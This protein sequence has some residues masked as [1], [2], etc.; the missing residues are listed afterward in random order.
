MFQR[1]LLRAHARVNCFFA[2]LLHH[3]HNAMSFIG[4]SGVAAR[5]CYILLHPCT[6]RHPSRGGGRVT[7]SAKSPMFFREAV[8]D[9]CWSNKTGVVQQGFCLSIMFSNVAE[10]D[11]Q[12]KSLLNDSCFIRPA[13]IMDS[14]AEK[15]GR[16][17]RKCHAP[18]PARRVSEGT[19]V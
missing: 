17:C 3:C 6:L 18:T 11:R 9:F 19:R 10:H 12:T 8:H 14:F 2:A 1:S 16:F 13:E 7:L 4:L 15:H 5:F